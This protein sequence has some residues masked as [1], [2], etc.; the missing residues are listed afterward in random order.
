M[1]GALVGSSYT[2]PKSYIT[3]S[4]FDEVIKE[5]SACKKYLESELKQLESTIYENYNSIFDFELL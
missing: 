1:S 3:K 5:L 4:E 2:N